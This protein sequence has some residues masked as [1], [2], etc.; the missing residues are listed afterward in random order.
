MSIAGAIGFRPRTALRRLYRQARR[1]VQKRRQIKRHA[2]GFLYQDICGSPV[3]LRDRGAYEHAEDV[4]RLCDEVYFRGYFPRPGD[5]VVDVGAGYGHEAIYCHARSPGVRYV[6]IEI[7][8]SVY[9]CLANTLR[10]CGGGLRAFPLA[11]S[12]SETSVWISSVMGRDYESV[13]AGMEGLVEIPAVP[14]SDVLQ[15]FSITSV[16]LLKVN[17][18]GGERYLLPALGNLER[19]NRVIISAHDFRADRGEGEHFRTRDFVLDYLRVSG[20][21]ARSLKDTPWW[22]DWIYAER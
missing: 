16:D 10:T 20:F 19:I 21:S 22:R 6:G 3:F 15:R 1:N 2:N 5:T 8:P 4:H 9:E 13:Q 14:W 18:E 17:I 11:I 12:A 7:Q